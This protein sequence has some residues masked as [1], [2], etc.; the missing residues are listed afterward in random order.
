MEYM[1]R[2]PVITTSGQSG[3][4]CFAE[5]VS[6]DYFRQACQGLDYLHYNKVLAL[7][8]AQHARPTTR[9]E[10]GSPSDPSA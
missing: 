5:E 3:F 9:P 7:A 2:G 4:P 8:A 1:E 10:A 6:L